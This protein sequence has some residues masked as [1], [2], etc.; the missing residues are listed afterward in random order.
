MKSERYSRF[1]GH[2]ILWAPT[3]RQLYL[4]TQENLL[5]ISGVPASKK[6]MHCIDHHSVMA[7]RRTITMI[8]FCVRKLAL[9]NNRIP[10]LRHMQW[11]RRKQPFFRCHS[12]SCPLWS[13]GNWYVPHSQLPIRLPWPHW[14]LQPYPYPHPKRQ[15]HRLFLYTFKQR[16]YALSWIKTI[17]LFHA[18]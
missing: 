4:I 3:P 5:H 13:N 9:W 18:W 15:V 14:S 11:L 7:C 10:V 8:V 2:L 1:V 16:R 6:I 12:L 17:L